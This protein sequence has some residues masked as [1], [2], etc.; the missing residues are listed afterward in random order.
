MRS[1]FVV[2]LLL[3]C[4]LPLG[5]ARAGVGPAD[6][7]VTVH[8]SAVAVRV[9]DTVS[10]TATVRNRGPSAAERAGIGFELRGPRVGD[11]QT[12]ASSGFCH[13][14]PGAG[15]DVV[16]ERRH[17]A[18]ASGRSLRFVLTARLEAPGNLQVYVTD[19]TT[20]K[21]GDRRNDTAVVVT[22]IRPS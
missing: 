3:F 17:P 5:V 11:E 8:A 9:G 4:G 10:Y 14:V 13:R 16:C 21:D 2:A 15:A 6:L 7:S 18:L 20:T 1:G 19:F 22:R 12:T